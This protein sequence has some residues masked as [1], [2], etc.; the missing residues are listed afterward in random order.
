MCD[1][2]PNCISPLGG[3]PN[4]TGGIR[5]IHDCSRPSGNSLN[6]YATLEFSQRFQTIDDASSL[7][8]PGYYMAKIDLKSVYRSVSVSE[9]RQQFTALKFVLNNQVVYQRDTNL[10]FGSRL[11]PGIFHRLS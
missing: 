7:L 6:D 8:Q 2:K 1:S 4:S 5:L 10:P 3:I 11:A 9:E